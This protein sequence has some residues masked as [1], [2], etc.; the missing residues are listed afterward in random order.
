MLP[1]WGSL[2][3][4]QAGVNPYARLFRGYLLESVQ[5]KLL[6]QADNETP[7]LVEE[8]MADPANASYGPF[9][10]QEGF[11]SFVAGF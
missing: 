11:A 6:S 10:A 2:L 1:L 3:F 8:P 7:I 9:V 5:V 4:R